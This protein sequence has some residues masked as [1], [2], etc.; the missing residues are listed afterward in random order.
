[1]PTLVFLHTAAVHVPTF[2]ALVAELAPGLPTRHIVAEGL[3]AEARA[4]GLTPALAARVAAQIAAA[5]EVGAVLCTCSTIGG[6]AE[7]TA[8]AGGP[9]VLRVDRA[10]AEAAVAAGPRIALVAALE[11][12]LAPTRALIAEV[13][14]QAGRAVEISEM[15]CAGAWACFEAGDGAGYLDAIEACVRATAASADVIVLAQASMA[16]AAQRC[17]DLAVPVLSSP[18]LGVAAALKLL[19]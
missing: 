14:A 12:T 18:R 1:M 6:L 15:L 8:T 7:A 9:P 11:S 16:G 13:A 17:A 4:E 3:L 19:G 10:M 2:S 5:G